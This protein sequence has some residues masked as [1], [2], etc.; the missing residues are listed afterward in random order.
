MAFWVNQ[1]E[2]LYE[3]HAP[4]SSEAV[5]VEKAGSIAAEAVPPNKSQH[6]SKPCRYGSSCTRPDCKFWHPE[7]DSPVSEPVKEDV[8]AKCASLGISWIPSNMRLNLLSSGKVVPGS[9]E[10][11]D[12]V[13]SSKE[14][15]L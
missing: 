5:E 15:E 2:L 9:S 7:G 8:G 1:M 10:S 13:V 4:K 3:E 11:N 14:Y 6:Q 12:S